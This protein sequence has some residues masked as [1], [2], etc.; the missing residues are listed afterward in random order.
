[1]NLNKAYS[2]EILNREYDHSDKTRQPL[3]IE[4]M[5]VKPPRD[6]VKELIRLTNDAEFI[7]SCD[8]IGLRDDYEGAIAGRDFVKR[9]FYIELV[10]P[11]LDNI[12][13]I[14]N[15]CRAAC[16]KVSDGLQSR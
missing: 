15:R 3:I 14:D 11:A 1:M 16:K 8:A 12:P 13:E 9:A 4:L 5:K 6:V 2:N 7:E 10:N